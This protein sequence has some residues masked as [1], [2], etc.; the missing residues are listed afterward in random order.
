MIQESFADCSV[1][2]TSHRD[3]PVDFGL[4]VGESINRSSSTYPWWRKTLSG[5]R[6]RQPTHDFMAEI[7]SDGTVFMREGIHIDL[8]ELRPMKKKHVGE[9]GAI[10]EKGKGKENC[11]EQ[12]PIGTLDPQTIH[13]FDPARICF[14]FSCSR[15][16]GMGVRLLAK[17]PTGLPR[18]WYNN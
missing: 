16:C 3:S 11:G 18:T 17:K 12:V 1:V 9:Q 2:G 10:C 8:R 5:N 14:C 13:T 15:R 7:A 6:K 4:L